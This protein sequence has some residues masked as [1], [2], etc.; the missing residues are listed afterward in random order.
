[1]GEAK[2]RGTFEERKALSGNPFK[3]DSFADLWAK[4]NYLTFILNSGAGK[5]MTPE[6]SNSANGIMEDLFQALVTK[7]GDKE[8]L[9]VLLAHGMENEKA[10]SSI[11]TP[12]SKIVA[13]DGRSMN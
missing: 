9:R 7:F 8:R 2:A 4:N 12:D 6:V 13:P 1:M 11:I 3:N 10:S 5:N